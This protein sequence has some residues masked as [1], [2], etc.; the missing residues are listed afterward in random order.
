VSVNKDQLHV[1]VLPEDDANFR[2]ATE[3]QAQIDFTRQR[4]MYVLNVANG[5]IK[6]LD[7]FASVHVREMRRYPRRFMVLLIDF[8]G[9]PNRLQ[10]AKSVIP[11]D[12]A[13]RVFV[14]GA[15]TEPEALK[16]ELGP[17]EQIGE[18][19]AKDCREQTDETWGRDSLRHNA[20]ELDRLRQQ[21][22]SILF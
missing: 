10:K 6:V 19:L 4:Q 13:E 20:G 3:F 5:W 1:F 8:D 11:V 18:D 2:L 7:I 9:E 17:Y 15:R 16:A 21:V 12:L 14:L 22:R